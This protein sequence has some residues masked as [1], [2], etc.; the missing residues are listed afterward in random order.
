MGLTQEFF[1]RAP[2]NEQIAQ[3]LAGRRFRGQ[4]GSRTY[5]GKTSN[6]IKNYYPSQAGAVPSAP[7]QTAAAPA[8]APAPAAAPA[9]APA[10]AAAPA[11]SAAP[12]A[13]F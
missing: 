2:T 9:P 4:V 10:P 12:S 6:E 5:N 7:A 1:D 8:P 13:P 11:P 3:G